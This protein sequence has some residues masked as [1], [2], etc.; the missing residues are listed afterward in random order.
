M[1]TY[2]KFEH[3][4]P[5]YCSVDLPKNNSRFQRTPPIVW[6]YPG[7]NKTPDSISQIRDRYNAVETVSQ[8]KPALSA[9]LR[10]DQIAT[11]IKDT[12]PSKTTPATLTSLNISAY[13]GYLILHRLA[14]LYLTINQYSLLAEGIDRTSDFYQKAFQIDLREIQKTTIGVG[15][16]QKE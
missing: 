13:Q 9:V 11:L 2:C 7:Q 12:S 14:H 3:K 1:N 8:G 4:G 15:M 5:S 6:S 10:P 16:Y